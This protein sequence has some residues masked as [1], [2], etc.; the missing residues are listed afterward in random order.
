[1]ALGAEFQIAGE[2]TA[3]VKVN[4]RQGAPSLKSPVIRKLNAGATVAVVALAVGDTVEGNPHWY[5]TSDSAFAW[6]GA[7]LPMESVDAAPQPLPAPAALSALPSGIN[8]NN[9][10]MVVD[11]FHED[12]VVSFDD[13][14]AAG[15]VG[16]I[17]KATTGKTG[18]DDAYP[19]RRNL[20]ASAGLLWGA[21]HWGTAMPAADQVSNFLDW[22]NPDKNTL[23]ALDFEQDPGNQMT[24]DIAREFL[25][26]INEK[27]N[28]KAVL[29]SGDVA[30]TDLGST[31]DTFFGSHRLWLCQ[32]GNKPSVQRSWKNFWLWQYTDGVKGPGRKTVPGIPGNRSNCLDCNYFPGTSADLQAQWAS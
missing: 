2:A 13:A 29:Y 3:S 30:K 1:M 32:Y 14:H 9:V 10:P 21:Y 31:N 5:K 4:L 25:G 17:H 22:A 11:I 19:T 16:V 23:V 20:A 27:L 12:G 24:L 6:S 8:L 28:R 18:R 7:F 15:L 26:L